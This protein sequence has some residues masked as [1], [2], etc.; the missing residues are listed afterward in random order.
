M[1]PS[2]LSCYFLGS[3]LRGS[4][5]LTEGST[6]FHCLG[7]FTASEALGY[8]S[9][10]DTPEVLVHE[11]T[12][13]GKTGAMAMGMYSKKLQYCFQTGRAHEVFFQKCE[14]NCIE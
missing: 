12:F 14:N 13:Q 3:P 6:H 2:S 4:A 11:E 5:L 9:C 1:V 7:E 10:L 8:E